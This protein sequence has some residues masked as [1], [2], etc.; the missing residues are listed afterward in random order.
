MNTENH[1]SQGDPK[2]EG[3]YLVAVRYPSGLGEYDFL[4]WKGQWL[5]IYDEERIPN[6]SKVVGFLSLSQVVESFTSS[7]PEW[8]ET[9]DK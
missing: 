4:M 1:W 8:D 2:Y 3:M 7:W 5:S 6:T 9:F